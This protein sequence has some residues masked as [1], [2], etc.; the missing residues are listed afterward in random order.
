MKQLTSRLTTNGL[1]LV[2]GNML[3]Y[4][5]GDSFVAGVELGDD[6]LPDYPG[7]SDFDSDLSTPKQWIA[8]TYDSKH[9]YSV[10]RERRNKELIELEYQRAFP[11]KLK[12]KLNVDV[13]NHAM[14]GSSMDRIVRTT[15][16]DLISLKKDHNNIVAIIGDTH[17]SRSEL[18][19]FEFIDST[20]IV[21]FTRHWV[22]LS[23]TYKMANSKPLDPVIEYKL[24][25]EKN[26]HM[27]VNYY[28]N[29]IRLQDFCKINNIKLY[30]VSSYNGID[31]V[32]VEKEYKDDL[33]LN[34]TIEY[35]QF[36]YTIGMREVALEIYN[37]VIC[38][39]G[40]FS[41]VVHEEVANRLVDIIKENHNV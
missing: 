23:T 1:G 37:N 30:W 10:E 12:N 26:Y 15:I 17:C 22:C 9:H 21:G 33:C 36:E 7:L 13:V 29:V 14:G 20:D 38:P 40:H 39:S 16:T 2:S 35:S 28:S 32:T 11:N 4:C 6:I 8:N 34:N 19:N 31:N 18:A 3:I 5:N 27:I 24:R 41:E 25:Y